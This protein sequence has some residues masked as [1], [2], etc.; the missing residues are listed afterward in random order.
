L[1]LMLLPGLAVL[2]INNYL[3]MFGLVMAFKDFKFTSRNFF[4]S[5]W[6]SKWIGLKNFEFFIKSPDAL[7]F[8]RNTLLYN[9]S[10]IVLTLL[11]AVPAAI[12]LNE[13]RNR[14]MAKLYQT[15][16]FLPQF[17][18]W[19]AVSYVAVAFLSY[20]T[21]FVNKA[22]LGPLGIDPVYWYNQPR[23]WPLILP[24]FYLWKSLGYSTIIYLAAATNIDAGLY[25]AA[26][27]DGA[28]K[29]K[30]V[31]YITVPM[32]IP[33]MITLSLLQIGR[34]FFADFGLFFQ[35]T[36]NIGSLYPT[37]MVIDTYVYNALRTMG[38]TGMSVA[39]GLYQAVVGLVFI[40]GCNFI[41]RK[42]DRN[43]AIF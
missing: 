39:V 11:L 7:I 43:S 9:L 31:R 6:N 13:L 23:Y 32:L 38:N 21:G 4:V 1:F 36:Q 25:E 30:Q 26:V 33:I 28:S 10:F 17:L 37:T 5:L 24:I 27:I 14:K 20:D 2:V 15:S 18:S 22:I 19:V 16:M 40:V 8:T 41:V 29:W 35:V 42:I 12:A 3:P 34:I